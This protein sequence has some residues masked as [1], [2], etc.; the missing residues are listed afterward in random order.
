MLAS[1]D[2]LNELKT[3][4]SWREVRPHCSILFLLK[5]GLLLLPRAHTKRSRSVSSTDIGI[6]EVSKKYN[7]R[8]TYIQPGAVDSELFEHISDAAIANRW[9]V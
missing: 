5:L 3:D 6:V 7:V 4:R 2:Y 9:K 1:A 8:V